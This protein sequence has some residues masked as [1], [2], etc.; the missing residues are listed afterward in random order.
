MLNGKKIIVGICGSISAYKAAS[1]VRLLIKEA[2]EVK[3]IMTPDA[4]K[5]IAPITLATLSKNEVL[6]DFY[7]QQGTWHNHVELAFWADLLVIAPATANTLAKMVYGMCDNMLLATY[8]SAK[9]PTIIAPAMD[10][11][12]YLH[13]ATQQNLQVLE[14]RNHYLMPAEKG[15]LASGIIG[16]GRLPE[17]EQIIE[18]IKENL[19]TRTTDPLPQPFEKIAPNQ[20]RLLQQNKTNPSTTPPINTTFWKNKK[21]LITAGATYEPIDPVRFIGNRS[22]G[23]MGIALAETA[24]QRGAHVTLILGNTHLQPNPNLGIELIKISTA[25]EMHQEAMQS[26][27]ETNIAILAAAVSDFTIETPSDTKIKKQ[28]QKNL[29]LKLAPTADILAQMGK[30]KTENQILVGF[31]L[32]T[33]NEIENATK[34]IKQKNL[35]LIVLNS[36]ANSGAGFQHDTNQITLINKQLQTFEYALK[37][38]IEVAN[39]ILDQ[40]EIL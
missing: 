9:C 2:A 24:A 13:P 20:A 32:E 1:L 35:D 11:D 19:P 25:A 34:K 14:S 8:L 16:I 27:A 15:E 30:Q 38:K 33:D 6:V 7:N 12:M 28:K 21:V 40:I 23:K 37:S 5:F 17:P 39:D 3:V 22:T 31:A 29:I 4:T 10:N 26:F 36:L 18:F